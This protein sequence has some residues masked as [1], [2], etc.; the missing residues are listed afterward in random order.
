MKAGGWRRATGLA[1]P[2]KYLREANEE[3]EEDKM[4]FLEVK[5]LSV[6]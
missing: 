3:I 5:L 6:D 1:S 4:V 2:A